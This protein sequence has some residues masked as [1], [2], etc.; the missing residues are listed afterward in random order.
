MTG[1]ALEAG[2]QA[3]R[4]DGARLLR[5]IADLAQVG[6]IEGGG[7]CR[8]ALTDADRQGRDLV[9]RWMRELGL[10]VTVDGIG[11][12]V[13]LRAGRKAGPPVMTGSHIDTV[14]TGGRYDGNLGVLAGLEVVAALNDAGVV[15]ERPIAVA[16]FTNEEGARF[17][18]DMM[19][20]LVF[21]GDLALEDALAT[22]G[23]DGTTVGENLARIGYAGTAPVGNNQVHAFV[24][25]HVEQGPVLEHEG[26]TIGA[27]TG[28]Q[29]IH[30]IEFTVRGVSNHAGTTPMGLRHDA[31]IVAARIACFARD[32]TV[33]LG[34]GQ[35]ATVGQV[36]LFPN[37]I[38]VI[39]N[40][41]TFTLD[42]RNTDGAALQEAIARCMT[43]AAQAAAAEGV[44]LS[45]RVL[46]DFAPVAFDE[47]IVGRVEDIARSRGHRVRRL[48]SGAGH[49]AQML[50]RMCPTGM[51]F[52]PSVGGLSHNV[53]E[54]TQDQ[55]IEAG[56][57]V[58]LELMLELAEQ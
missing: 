18:P 21:Q 51:V 49:D 26:Y 16:F 48:P 37:L 33:E 57:G 25:L 6:A 31:G 17:A 36:N 20:S 11:N 22:V 10:A 32:L 52:V 38:N 41:A 35:L 8:L 45:H 29:G 44:E 40:R 3:V 5:R 54:F 34:A 55:D 23:I 14:R 2:R 24:E 53:A 12:V 43:Y 30:W 58:L 47:A 15:T 19:G 56:A 7:V 9:V 42:L 50:A 28:V 39:P 1:A 46:A 13:G 4:V 27:V